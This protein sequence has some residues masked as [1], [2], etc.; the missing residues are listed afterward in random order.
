MCWNPE[1]AV[2][3]AISTVITYLSGI[4][5]DKSRTKGQKKW[6]VAAS[7]ITN[8]A[9]LF[10]FKYFYFTVD[11]INAVRTIMNLPKIVPKFDVILP[12][13]ISFYTFQALSYTVDVYRKDVKAE[14][15][16]LKYALFVSFFPQLVAGPIERSKELLKQINEEHHFDY[17]R[18]RMGL[19]MM[20]WGFF[21]KLVIADRAA[22]LVNFVYDDLSKFSGAQILV[23][24][25]CF[26]AQI[27][28]D[29]ASYSTIARGAAV[30]MGFN[31][32]QNFN[33]PYFATSIAEF[34]RNWHISLST[35]FRDYLY[36]P[37]GGNRKGKIRKYFN[38]MVVFLASG[39]W[40]G[41]S[42]NFVVWGAIHGAYQIF[43]DVTKTMRDSVKKLFKIKENALYRWF[44]RFFVFLLVSLAWIFFRSSN[45]SE[46]VFAI[47]TIFTNFDV[48]EILNGKILNLGLDYANVI[49]LVSA[50]AVLFLTSLVGTKCEMASKIEKS[51]LLI[52]WP[53]YL[54]LIFTVLIFGI[55]GPGFLASQFIYFQF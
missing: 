50:I 32:M 42:W 1:Y 13:G 35:W 30:V 7:F 18:V 19:L 25:F 47:K 40:H 52:R 49:V 23:A 48:Q 8:L 9:I 4:F 11:N 17:E 12:V 34:W 39:L 44:Q 55:Y 24:T 31:L 38:L 21:L 10:Y 28:C 14:K 54:L 6:V 5:I 53:I 46:S 45:I 2:L 43:G 37:L 29:F 20:L 41:A 27:Y 15:N 33:K 26:A 36:I 51:I 22:I 16:L 3:I